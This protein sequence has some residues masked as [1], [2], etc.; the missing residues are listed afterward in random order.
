MIEIV[1]NNFTEVLLMR[2]LVP[3]TIVGHVEEAKLELC[4]SLKLLFRQ[5]DSSALEQGPPLTANLPISR[6]MYVSTIV[7]QAYPTLMESKIVL[8]CKSPL[9]PDALRRKVRSGIPRCGS[10]SC[11]R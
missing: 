1:F 4:S 7:S 8:S 5:Y 10:K 3:K 2:Y 11:Y 9:L 6:L